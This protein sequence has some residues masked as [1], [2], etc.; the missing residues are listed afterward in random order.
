MINKEK[1]IGT[2]YVKHDSKTEIGL[3]VFRMKKEN[4]AQ[5]ID[6]ADICKKPDG[7]AKT[8]LGEQYRSHLRY[9]GV[10]GHK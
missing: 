4:S 5:G 1:G 6:R 7:W 9:L 8:L 2:T 10:K 3:D